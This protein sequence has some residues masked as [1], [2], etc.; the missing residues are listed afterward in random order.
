MDLY[1]LRHG[2]AM[3][4]SPD[5]DQLSDLG[6]RQA[7]CLGEELADW[8]LSDATLVSG[9][10]KRQ[11]QTL[12]GLCRGGGFTPTDRQDPGFNEL[13]IMELIPLYWPA[14]CERLGLSLTP[15][16]A[17]QDMRYFLPLMSEA[18][19][20]WIADH[21]QREGESFSQFRHRVLEAIAEHHQG[22]KPTLA[23]TSGGVISLVAGEALGAQASHMAELIH[24]VNNCSITHLRYA[25]GQWQMQAFNINGHLRR[26]DML[27]WR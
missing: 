15:K 5:Y 16:E 24:Q 10:L 27:T 11:R 14:A 6:Q 8:N 18:L 17:S 26:Q 1:L 3:F 19:R 7:L 23:V 2:Q 4:G 9:S 20:V 25:R 22:N 13:E 12:E 21:G